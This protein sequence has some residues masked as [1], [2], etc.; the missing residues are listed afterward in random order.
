MRGTKKLISDWNRTRLDMS[1]LSTALIALAL[2]SL[3]KN[4]AN[5]Q[6]RPL[7]ELIQQARENFK[8]ISPEQVSQARSE[9]TQRMSEVERWVGAST[10]N[11][12]RWMRYLRGTTSNKSSLTK[13]L[14]TWKYSMAH[15]AN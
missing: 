3:S 10:A 6:E 2:L 8:P 7:P 14:P 9:L 12:Q 13:G 5:G 11:G 1:T 15:S 4:G